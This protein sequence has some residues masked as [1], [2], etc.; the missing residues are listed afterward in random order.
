[1]K[2]SLY[3][4]FGVSE[5][6]IVDP[7]AESVEVFRLSGGH[8]AASLEYGKDDLLTSPLFPG[9]SIPLSEVFSS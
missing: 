1:M 7:K 9:L 8:Y 4:R 6:W 2:H 3:E 5:Y